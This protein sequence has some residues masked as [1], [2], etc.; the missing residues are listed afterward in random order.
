MIK[1]SN[2]IT[3]QGWMINHLSLKPNELIVYAVIFGFSQDGESSFEG[4]LSYLCD[5]TK[6]TKPTIISILKKLVESDLV[7]KTSETKNNLIFNKYKANLEIIED[8]NGS[9]NSLMGYAKN[10]NGGSKNSLPNNNSNNNSN[11]DTRKGIKKFLPPTEEEVINYFKE[12]GYSEEGA[13]TAFKY[14]E[15]GNWHDAKNN[16]IKSWKQKMIAVWFRPEYKIQTTTQN[17][18]VF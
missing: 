7:I 6:S 12:N 8:F 11:T 1:D 15:A 4:S 2:Y 18:L 13:K 16:P 14:Y 10:L 17:K 9:K 3:V 5:I